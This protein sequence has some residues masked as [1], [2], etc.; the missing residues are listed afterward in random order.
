VDALGEFE[1]ALGRER[2]EEVEALEDEADLAAADV[3]AAGVGG[4]RQVF[5]V[6]HDAPGRR[7]Q[8]PAEEVQHGGLAAA[9]RPHDGEKLA[10]LDLQRHA[11]QRRHVH[12]PHA[13]DLRQF[14]CDQNLSHHSAAGVRRNKIRPRLVRAPHS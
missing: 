3:C 10:L 5:V 2:R 9:R 7:R 4:G 14:I 1:I 13:V 8:E 6:D 12:R 11:A